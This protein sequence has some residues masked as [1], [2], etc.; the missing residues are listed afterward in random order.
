ME[1]AAQLSLANSTHVG[2]DGCITG[3]SC[4]VPVKLFVHGVT[5]IMT[6]RKVTRR[7]A[8]EVVHMLRDDTKSR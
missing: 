6:C 3:K 8:V 4:D 7:R 2:N 5:C 1:C